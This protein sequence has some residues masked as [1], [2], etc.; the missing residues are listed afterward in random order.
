MALRGDQINAVSSSVSLTTLSHSSTGDL[1]QVPPQPILPIEI[2]EEIISN[3]PVKFLSQLRCICKS[4]NSLISD[5]KFT[6]RHLRRS[7]RRILIVRFMNRSRDIN[8]MSYPLPSILKAVT[9]GGMQLDNPRE[10]GNRNYSI[11]G[12]CDGIICRCNFSHELGHS[13]VVWNPSINKFWELT[14]L[15]KPMLEDC[16]GGRAFHSYGFGYDQL[17]NSF[18]L[19]VIFHYKCCSGSY[20]SHVMVHTLGSNFW[21]KIEEFPGIP[22]CASGNNG[23]C[24]SGAI[25]WLARGTAGIISLNL[26]KE[27]YKEFL[28]PDYGI[29]VHNLTMEIVRDCLCILTN[30]K[31]VWIMK[32]YGNTKSWTKLFSFPSYFLRDW[33]PYHR[34]YGSICVLEDDESLFYSDSGI[35][36]F[37]YKNGT[38]RSSSELEN[39]ALIKDTQAGIMDMYVEI[40]SLISPLP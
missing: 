21:R 24:V 18:K 20:K 12:S 38:F 17:S 28:Q 6:R 4:W 1:Y 23:I 22:Y 29:K 14:P 34:A 27:S 25:N 9:T 32:E 30:S 31:D 19:V 11:I 40:E 7:N 16:D 33:F 13:F 2:V 3:L 37:S 10:Y 8:Y 39:P 35:D 36:I 26:G 15:E 5:P